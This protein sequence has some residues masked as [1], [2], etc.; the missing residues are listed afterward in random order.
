LAD[1]VRRDVADVLV[2]GVDDDAQIAWHGWPSVVRDAVSDGD[3]RRRVVRAG[4][5]PRAG[6]QPHQI[7]H[8]HQSVVE[9]VPPV[10]EVDVIGGAFG[11]V[12]DVA[13]EVLAMRLYALLRAI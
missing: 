5:G 3:D 1:L 6:G 2:T 10:R 8:P 11:E 7:A 12:V 4:V 13:A 9:D